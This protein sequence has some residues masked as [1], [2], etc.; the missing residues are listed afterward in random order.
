[1]KTL[2][3]LNSKMWYRLLKVFF[4]II[5]ISSLLITGF[6]IYNNRNNA[7]EKYITQEQLKLML[8]KQDPKLDKVRIVENLVSKGLIIKD[9]NEPKLSQTKEV[10]VY[11]FINALVLIVI[12]R[13]FY[14]IVLGT[15][16]P[17]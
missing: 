16:R 6:I 15:V 11:L 2:H 8:E 17:K 13:V 12:Q 7:K 10:L 3:E 14:Y 9:F 1:M 4:I 5:S